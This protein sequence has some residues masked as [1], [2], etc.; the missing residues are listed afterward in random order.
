MAT[1]TLCFLGVDCWSNIERIHAALNFRHHPLIAQFSRDG[2]AI[3]LTYIG[4]DVNCVGENGDKSHDSGTGGEGEERDEQRGSKCMEDVV[5]D[6]GNSSGSNSILLGEVRT[7]KGGGSCEHEEK[8]NK[9]E[10]DDNDDL[11]DVQ[12]SFRLVH[13]G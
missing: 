11:V 8:T 5:I 7:Y 12:P 2:E 1:V 4:T 3:K 13:F 6:I 10:E 9:G